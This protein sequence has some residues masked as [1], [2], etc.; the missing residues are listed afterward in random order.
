MYYVR[1][2][3]SREIFLYSAFRDL[4]S[5]I[6]I[7]VSSDRS[8]YHLGIDYHSTRL[9]WIH[10]NYIYGCDANGNKYEYFITQK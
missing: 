10:N 4:F 9:T 3:N 5:K 8:D 7:L 2:V 6:H 1:I